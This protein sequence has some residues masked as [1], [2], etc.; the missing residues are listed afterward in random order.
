[1]NA[2][3]LNSFG[4]FDGNIYGYQNRKLAGIATVNTDLLDIPQL[5][6]QQ[7]TQYLRQVDDLAD[8]AEM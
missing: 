3:I 6:K 4:A 5:K 2:Q 1:M 8:Y 7:L